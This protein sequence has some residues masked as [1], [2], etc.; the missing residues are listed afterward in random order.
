MELEFHRKQHCKFEGYF[1][2]KLEY[3]ELEFHSKLKFHKLEFQK[4]GKLLNILQTMIDLYIFS[5]NMAIWPINSLPQFEILEGTFLKHLACLIFKPKIK[6]CP[7]TEHAS[8]HYK[9]TSVHHGKLQNNKT[10]YV[11]ILCYFAA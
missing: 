1:L 11:L 7:F 5:Q 8:P 2:K 6:N 4:S 10:I 9:T 3:L